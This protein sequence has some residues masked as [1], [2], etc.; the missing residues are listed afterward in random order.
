M[1]DCLK[2]LKKLIGI[3]LSELPANM[4]NTKQPKPKAFVIDDDRSIKFIFEGALS[5]AGYDVEFASNYDEAVAEIDKNEFDVIFSD[6]LLGGKTGI[7]F[8]HEVKKRKLNTPVIMMTA[9]PNIDSASEAVRLGAF[10][11]IPKP[12]QNDKLVRAANMAYKHKVLVDK[13]DRYQS[14]LEAVFRSVKDAIVT[15]DKKLNVVSFNETAKNNYG[16]S[17][18]TIG[19]RFDTLSNC[20]NP[21]CFKWLEESIAEN[22]SLEINRI[23]WQPVNANS[24]IVSINISPL[25]DNN[26]LLSGA[27]MV[28]R[29]ETKLNSL[30]RDLKSRRQLHNIIGKSDKMQ[31]LYNLIETLA[32]VKSTVLI[33]GE[34]GT[35]KELVAAALHHSG[36]RKDAPFIAVNCSALPDAL[37]ESELFGHVKGAFTGAERDRPGKFEQAEGGTI[38][39]DEIGDISVKAQLQLLRILQEKEVVRLGGVKIIKIDV[40]IVT[41]TNKNLKKMIKQGKFR[42]DLFYRLKVLTIELPS[43][44]ERKE[45]IPQL[46]E[47]FI[48]VFNMELGK[49]IKSVSTDVSQMFLGHSWPGNVRELRHTIEHACI[50]C[51]GSMITCNDLPHDLEDSIS[52]SDSTKT[53]NSIGDPQLVVD[54][55]KK[56]G[57]NKAKAARSLGVSRMTLYR[58]MKEHGIAE[59]GS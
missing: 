36:C 9:S 52:N 59:N 5:D 19:E 39:L 40:R 2:P 43:L 37:I 56:T 16:F 50:H 12:I 32:D 27:V 48:D 47:Y 28:I 58:K 26:K 10:D 41:A 53:A 29:D 3:G 13:I 24:R 7:D 8:L 54:A 51:S 15:V 33:T 4:T 46:V 17:G 31:E 25:I 23:E 57:W 55:L 49:E 30:E 11:Y 42:E 20:G 6:I 1:K 14:N 22:K 45:D 35:G 21:G 38:F 34:T 18:D 44:K